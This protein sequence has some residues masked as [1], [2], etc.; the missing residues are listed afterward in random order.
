MIIYL[1]ALQGVPSELYESADI[2]GAGR[3]K[4]MIKITIPM[5]SPII[6]FN[7]TTSVMGVM[8][9]FGPAFVLTGGGP[10]NATLF[11]AL[12][13]YRAALSLQRWGYAAALS[14]FAAFISLIL[15]IIVF[16]S[17]PMWVF[18]E[19]IKKER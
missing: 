15:T 3:W 13:V 5:V 6:F 11:F 17:S 1:A 16:R 8:G 10:N 12:Y 9:F 4:K 2:D 19:T 7:V 14:W 18:Y